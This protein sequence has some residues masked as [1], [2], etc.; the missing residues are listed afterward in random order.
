MNNNYMKNIFSDRLGFTLIELLVVLAI[1]GIIAVA[2]LE[3][4]NPFA[5]IQKGNDSRRK[6]DLESVQRALELYYQD[7][8][9]YPA[10]SSTYQIAPGGAAI[11]WGNAWSPYM[12]KL[13]K[14]PISTDNY[15]YYSPAGN[16]SYYLYATLQRGANDP[17]ACNKGLACT[18]LSG[19]GFPASSACGG[20]TA[21]CNYGVS[22]SNVSP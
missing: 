1:L 12:S 16:Q 3:T 9:S 22:S 13:P 11:A 15:V 8:G 5:Q 4:L 20:T 14:D 19:S 21:I 17:Q 6:S 18:S 2:L 10:S 7:K